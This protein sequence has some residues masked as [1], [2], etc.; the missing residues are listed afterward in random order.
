MVWWGKRQKAPQKLGF[1]FTFLIFNHPPSSSTML[2][3]QFITI[4]VFNRAQQ[5]S[6]IRKTHRRNGGCYR[7]PSAGPPVCFLFGRGDAWRCPT[8]WVLDHSWVVGGWWCGSLVA[9]RWL[10]MR[11]NV[12]EWKLVKLTQYYL[13]WGCGRYH[14]AGWVRCGWSGMMWLTLGAGTCGMILK[15]RDVLLGGWP[16]VERGAAYIERWD[17]LMSDF[18]N[19]CWGWGVVAGGH[20]F[21]FCHCGQHLSMTWAWFDHPFR[22]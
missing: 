13:P 9:Q 16:S 19:D 20:T 15:P 5:A 2:L 12:S 17:G 10:R 4:V 3:Q 14:A 6:I 8:W 22:S 18:V 1:C 21:V 7:F 11:M